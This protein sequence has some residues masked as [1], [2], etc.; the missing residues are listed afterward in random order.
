MQDKKVPDKKMSLLTV[1]FSTFNS[2]F[3]IIQTQINNKSLYMFN[4]RQNE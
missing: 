4:K 3:N 2:I 1:Y